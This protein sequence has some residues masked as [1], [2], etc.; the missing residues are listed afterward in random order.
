M[1]PTSM[2]KIT[3][4][5]ETYFHDQVRG[6]YLIECERGQRWYEVSYCPFETD[7]TNRRIQICHTDLHEKA[8]GAIESHVRKL[9]GE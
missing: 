6:R 1:T 4:I 8:V 2:T 7:T 3:I 5:R 9:R